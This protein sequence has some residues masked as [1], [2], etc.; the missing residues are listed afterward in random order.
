M[1]RVLVLGGLGMLGHQLAISLASKH[2][3]TVSIRDEAGC[4]PR[5]T[6]DVSVIGGLNL[7]DAESLERVVSCGGFD[8][9][10]N[11][12]G[13]IKH[14]QTGDNLAEML[15]VNSV[16]PHILGG[17]C[18]MHRIR[19]VQFSTD[20]VFSGLRDSSR[21]PHGYRLTDPPDARDRYGLSKLLGEV[22]H[23]GAIT[24]RTSL[25][26]REIRQR[27]GLLEWYLGEN[28]SVVPGYM[29]ARFSGITTP[30][31]ARLVDRLVGDL[32]GLDGLWHVAAS[33]ISKHDLL[34]LVHKRFGR[35]PG[36]VPESSFYCDRRLDGGEFSSR[37]G[38]RAPGWEEM[39]DELAQRH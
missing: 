11:A 27:R 37:T 23:G 29:N 16:L 38:W 17:L 18:R 7:C 5:R 31:A 28:R 39:I 32:E 13:V 2:E 36:I 24:L 22:D 35:G 33:P 4:W 34:Q 1:S 10:V 19:L 3:I 30:V 20:C 8:A 26:G 6:A 12:A 15:F 9:V 14:R 21:G 25:I